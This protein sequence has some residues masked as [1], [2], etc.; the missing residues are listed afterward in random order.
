MK[1]LPKA[2]QIFFTDDR[3]G[4]ELAHDCMAEATSEV[5]TLGPSSPST[6]MATRS[7]GSRL[8]MMRNARPGYALATSV[9]CLKAGE[10]TLEGTDGSDRIKNS[11]QYHI[12]ILTKLTLKDF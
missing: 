10:S 5:G 2:I 4:N 8:L 1:R 11:I 3:N 9:R 6:R 12:N 7:A